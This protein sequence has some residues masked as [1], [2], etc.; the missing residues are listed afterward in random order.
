MPLRI[1]KQLEQ[2]ERQIEELRSYLEQQ[3]KAD[4][5][6]RER[7]RMA[8][9]EVDLLTSQLL[10]ELQASAALRSELA[11]TERELVALRAGRGTSSSD[12]L[13]LTG[14]Q[15]ETGAVSHVHAYSAGRE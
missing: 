14:L 3:A 7:L 2:Q 5:A 15:T 11:A 8:E 6:G 13:A 4:A 9:R 10:V 1:E 12:N